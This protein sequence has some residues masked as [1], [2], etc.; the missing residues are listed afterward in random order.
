[1]SFKEQVIN[2]LGEYK[3]NSL[4]ISE[5]GIYRHKGKD[6]FKEHILPKEQ[7]SYNIISQYRDEFFKSIHSDIDFHKYFHHLNSSQA[8]CIN[9]FFPVIIEN[10]LDIVRDLLGLQNKS[11]SNPRFEKESD[12]EKVKGG[13]KKTNFDFHFQQSSYSNIFFEI[14]Y[15]EADF[16]KAK[17]D[18]EHR[19]KFART[20]QPLLKSNDF[21]NKE[22]KKMDTFFNSYQIIRNLVHI[23]END[24]VVFI[25]PKANKKV[26]QQAQSAYDNILNDNGKK[27]FKILLLETMVDNILEQIGSSKLLDH[28]REFQNKY[29]KYV[30]I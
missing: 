27:R 29:L 4:G 16:G 19:A 13:E 20:Y 18:E 24:I 7:S 23:N 6:I 15:T 17:N 28:Y 21:I 5:N 25:Y 11:I 30:T 1:M 26:H 10:K 22:Y 8:L 14:K 9:L 2:Y 12:L 3:R